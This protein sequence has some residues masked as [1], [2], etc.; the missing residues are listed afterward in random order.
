[1]KRKIASLFHRSQRDMTFGRLIGFLA[2]VGFFFMGIGLYG[3][4]PQPKF[5]L[6][7]MNSV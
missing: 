4:F 3:A 7:T 1:M 2:G 5:K 6:Q